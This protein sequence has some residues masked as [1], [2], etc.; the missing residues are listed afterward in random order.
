M[1]A[2]HAVLGL[3]IEKPGYG[4]ELAQRLEER[5][6][7]WGWQSQGVYEA[8]N[9]LGRDGHVQSKGRRGS[10]ATGR[11]APRTIYEATQKGV[12][13]HAAWLFR[14]SPLKPARQELDLKILFA[15]PESLARLIEQTYAQEQQCIDELAT[16]T[17]STAAREPDAVPR[18]PESSFLLIRNWEIKKLESRI[19]EMQEARSLM[20][21]ILV[22]GGAQAV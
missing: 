7:A 5:C 13:F 10:S 6:G 18:W 16:L 11:A 3:V 14:S 15:G 1:S 9:L 17:S 4:Y 19:A 2:K 20:K 12:D 8:L 21:E 22:S